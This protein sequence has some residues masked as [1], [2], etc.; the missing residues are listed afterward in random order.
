M[1]QNTLHYSRIESN[2]VRQYS[3]LNLFHSAL[4]LPHSIRP[5]PRVVAST[6]YSTISLINKRHNVRVEDFLKLQDD[7]FFKLRC[8][9]TYCIQYEQIK[10]VYFLFQILNKLFDKNEVLNFNLFRFIEINRII[11]FFYLKIEKLYMIDFDSKRK[12]LMI[13]CN[14][15]YFHCT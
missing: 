1:Y 4:N 5:D 8:I 6:R 12:N 13:T 7:E 14:R 11:S 15:H 10:R 2:R 3:A 9:F